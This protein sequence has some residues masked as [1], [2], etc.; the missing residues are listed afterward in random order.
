[1]QCTN[2]RHFGI[3]QFHYRFKQI[4]YI[5]F[6]HLKPYAPISWKLSRKA[7]SQQQPKQ[8][9]WLI[10]PLEFRLNWWIMHRN[11]VIKR[12]C[13]IYVKQ[14]RSNNSVHFQAYQTKTQFAFVAC[15]SPSWCES[16]AH[17]CRKKLSQ[18]WH[19]HNRLVSGETSRAFNLHNSTVSIVDAR[20]VYKFNGDCVNRSRNCV[21]SFAWWI[22]FVSV[23]TDSSITKYFEKPSKDNIQTEF[24]PLKTFRFLLFASIL[25]SHKAPSI[26]LISMQWEFNS[27]LTLLMLSI[28]LNDEPKQSKELFMNFNEIVQCFVLFSLFSFCISRSK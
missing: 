26:H 28:E 25:S 14:Y 1:M 20:I 15:Q 10:D 13:A 27:M 12:I 4:Q 6:R 23:S 16:R 24:I 3:E 9:E 22:R 18:R 5:H 21:V 2:W 7:F 8:V 11:V 19:L 17:F